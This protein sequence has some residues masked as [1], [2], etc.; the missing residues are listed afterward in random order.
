MWNNLPEVMNLENG[1]TRIQITKKRKKSISLK[2]LDWIP[3]KGTSTD[4]YNIKSNHKI[5]SDNKTFDVITLFIYW[6]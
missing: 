5:I 1:I 6:P 3:Y 4:L 2:I